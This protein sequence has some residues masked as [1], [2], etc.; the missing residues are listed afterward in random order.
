MTWILI[1][2]LG[3]IGGSI[4]ARLL[5]H[6]KRDTFDITILIRSAAKAKDFE[7]FGLKVLVGSFDDLDVL[8]RLSS[9]SDVVFQSVKALLGNI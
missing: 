6:P 8:E 2:S 1:R 5:E 3:Y 7:S 4:L 9:E